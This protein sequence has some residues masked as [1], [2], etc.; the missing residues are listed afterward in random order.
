VFTA[1]YAL[2]PYIKQIRFVFKGLREKV[3]GCGLLIVAEYLHRCIRQWHSGLHKTRAVL[4]Y[5]WGGA[6]SETQSF[7][8]ELAGFWKRNQYAVLCAVCVCALIYIHL[9]TRFVHKR[10]LFFGNVP[11]WS[12]PLPPLISSPLHVCL[13]VGLQRFSVTIVM[14]NEWWECAKALSV[15]AAM[16]NVWTHRSLAR[17][18]VAAAMLNVWTHRSLARLTIAAAMLNVWTHRSLARLTVLKTTQFFK[19]QNEL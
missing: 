10:L 4:C 16:L 5:V 2:S 8:L 7:T 13:S 11:E 19:A 18:A 6:T 1:R 12:P 9:C 17:L 15:A 3:G 14:R